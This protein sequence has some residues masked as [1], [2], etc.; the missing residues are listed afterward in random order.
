MALTAENRQTIIDQNNVWPFRYA[1]QPFSANV[2]ISIPIF[3]GFNR[4]LRISQAAAA[5]DDAEEVVRA[6]RLQVR[7]DVQGKLIGV[8][9]A[10]Q[11]IA[12]QDANQ[13]AAREQLDLARERFRLGNGSALEVS[14]AQASVARAEGDYVNAVY[15]Y[16]KAIAAL[17]FAVGRPLR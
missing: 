6:T 5:R 4:N 9:T 17:E 13:R 10:Y 2:Q 11:S 3:T 16:H 1:A 12:V 8:E 15:D 14:D 7:S